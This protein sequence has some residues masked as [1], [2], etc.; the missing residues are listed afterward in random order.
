LQGICSAQ[1]E[2]S[3]GP[4]GHCTLTRHHREI[5]GGLSGLDVWLFDFAIKPRAG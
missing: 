1:G 4:E 3:R 2:E 5:N